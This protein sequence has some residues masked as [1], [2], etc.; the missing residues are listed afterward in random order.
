MNAAEHDAGSALPRR[1]AEGVAA[2]RIPG[3]DA[4]ADHVTGLDAVEI[5]KLEG[6][7]ADDRVAE[8]RGRG[9]REHEEPT[10]SDHSRPEGCVARVDEMD[11]HEMNRGNQV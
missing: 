7:I 6:F 9:G 5:E 10:G 4:D 2:Q 3:V 11:F 1:A 8:G